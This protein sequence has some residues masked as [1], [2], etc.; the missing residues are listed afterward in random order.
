LD[1]KGSGNEVLAALASSSSSSLRFIRLTCYQPSRGYIVPLR[2]STT[3]LQD[4]VNNLHSVENVD[5]EIDSLLIEK[6]GG[7]LRDSQMSNKQSISWSKLE[8]LNSFRLGGRMESLVLHPEM[9]SS[10]K[11]LHN[12][13]LINVRLPQFS[14][15]MVTALSKV[16]FLSLTNVLAA[17]PRRKS[18]FTLWNALS[19]LKSLKKLNLIGAGRDAELPRSALACSAL[20]SLSIQDCSHVGNWPLNTTGVTDSRPETGF[21]AVGTLRD[22]SLRDIGLSELPSVHFWRSCQRLTSLT[23]RNVHQAALRHRY[24]DHDGACVLTNAMEPVLRLLRVLHLEFSGMNEE[25]FMSTARVLHAA[26]QLQELNL[27]GNRLGGVHGRAIINAIVHDKLELERLSL[28]NCGLKLV[29][30]DIFSLS[31]L[32]ELDLSNNPSLQTGDEEDK[33][34]EKVKAVKRNDRHAGLAASLPK[35][36]EEQEGAAIVSLGV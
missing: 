25:Q 17:K 9:L 27:Q 8:K 15:A 26:T 10:L 30:S 6:G 20:T 33:K 28:V 7:G 5:L 13:E 1:Y 22:L 21:P 24:W 11:N 31:S 14:P 12:L 29:P 2:L 3:A 36:S 18:G 19:G 23:W 4:L 34:L 16:S 35:L 32:N